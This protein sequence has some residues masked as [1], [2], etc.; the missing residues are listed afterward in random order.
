[1][2]KQKLLALQSNDTVTHYSKDS[3]QGSTE[4]QVVL[5]VKIDLY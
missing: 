4:Q 3:C 5:A 2:S 1:M